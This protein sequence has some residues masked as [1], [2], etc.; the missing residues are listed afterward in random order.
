MGVPEGCNRA[1]GGE[2]LFEEIMIENFIELMKDA[3]DFKEL[4]ESQVE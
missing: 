2:V 3:S 1:V 4:S